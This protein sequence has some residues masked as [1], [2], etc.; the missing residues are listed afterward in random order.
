[1]SFDVFIAGIGGQGTIL[2]SNIIGEACVIEGRSVRGAE[3]HGMAQRGGSVECQVRIDQE[4]GAHIAPGEAD[5]MISFD[6]LE[7]ARHSHYMKKE[8]VIVTN[9]EYVLPT[10]VFVQDLP[11]PGRELLLSACT[12]KTVLSIDAKTLAEQAGTILTQNVVLLGAASRFI[13]LQESSLREAVARKVP[14][15]SKEMNLSAF[16]LGQRATEN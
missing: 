7:T 13:P 2:L 9:N 4:F 14:E 6:L 5:L 10:S 8:G 3:T 11:D 1:M 16:D 12:T 15:K